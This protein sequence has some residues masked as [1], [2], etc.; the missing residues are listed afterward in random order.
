MMRLH[1]EVEEINKRKMTN[2]KKRRWTREDKRQRIAQHTNETPRS[3]L[4]VCA[5]KALH[6]RSVKVLTPF[7][8]KNDIVDNDDDDKED[9]QIHQ[10]SDIQIHTIC[11]ANQQYSTYSPTSL[12]QTKTTI[13]VV[14]PLIIFDVNGI[15]CHRIRQ[16]AH[17]EIPYRQ[18][19]T[20]TIAKTPIIPRPN[21][22]EFL[23]FLSQHFCLAIWTVRD[24]VH[25][26]K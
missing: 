21:L 17:P 1:G 4:R 14:K 11:G 23:S 16:D 26:T 7:L 10:N 15:L 18:S 9:S 20:K 6:T 24:I 25:S 5:R 19:T 13:I 2:T 3:S 8:A 22:D 12:I